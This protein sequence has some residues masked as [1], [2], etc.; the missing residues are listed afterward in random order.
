MKF[1]FNLPS[2][3]R[4]DVEIVDGQRTVPG[5]TGILLAHP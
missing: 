4:G 2:G 5:V 1:I 3:F